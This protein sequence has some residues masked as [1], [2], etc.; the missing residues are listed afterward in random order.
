MYKPEYI[1]IFDDEVNIW[2]RTVKLGGPR[3][4]KWAHKNKYTEA[5]NTILNHWPWPVIF[6]LVNCGIIKSHEDESLEWT[7]KNLDSLA[8]LFHDW[9]LYDDPDMPE[10]Y[11]HIRHGL[12]GPIETA[13]NLKRYSLR[14]L[15]S[16]NGRYYD[17]INPEYEKVIEALRSEFG[18]EELERWN[19]K[20][21]QN[22]QK[23]T[24]WK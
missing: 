13:F 12:W 6:P 22:R 5:I 15:V 14:Y 7:L 3:Y 4:N 18:Q 21:R 20:L 8:Q 9:P 1:K 17:R 11:K 19:P 10:R 23:G 16:T 2:V 24:I